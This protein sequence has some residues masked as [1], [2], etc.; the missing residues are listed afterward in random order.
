MSILK[1]FSRQKCEKNKKKKKKKRNI[2]IKIN[3]KE[4][5]IKEYKNDDNDARDRGKIREQKA[6]T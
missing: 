3:E 2:I 1:T 4:K 5:I 6:S